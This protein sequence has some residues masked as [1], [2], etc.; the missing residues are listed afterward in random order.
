[1]KCIV[2]VIVESSPGDT[3][4]HEIVTL[5][6]PDLLSPATVGL[7]IAE[8]KAVQEGLQTQMVAAQVGWHNVSLRSCLHCG[9]AFRTKGYYQST[10]SSVYGNVPMRIRRLRGCSCRGHRIG[11]TRRSSR[12]TSRSPRSSDISTPRWPLCCP[13]EKPLIFLANSYQCR[14]KRRPAR[15]ATGR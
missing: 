5:G 1:M 4:E 13:L 14:R 3:V 8:G 2:K 15:C 12:T 9:R 6:R 11:A 7:S 10:L